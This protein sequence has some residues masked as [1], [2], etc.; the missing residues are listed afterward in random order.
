M[1]LRNTRQRNEYQELQL[2]LKGKTI[3]KFKLML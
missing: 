3:R 2:T 1:E